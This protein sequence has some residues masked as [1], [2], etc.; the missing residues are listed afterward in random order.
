[1]VINLRKILLIGGGIFAA[2]V[3]IGAAAGSNTT[4]VTP[5]EETSNTKTAKVN[6]TISSGNWEYTV[7]KV[8]RGDKEVAWSDFGNKTTAKGEFVLVYLTLKNI[9]KENFTINSFDFELRDANDV[10]Y[11]DDST[12]SFSVSDY[13]NLGKLGE[14]MPPGV[15]VDT[16][17]VYDVA[18]SAT[19]LRLVLKQANESFITLQQ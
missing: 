15:A 19:D 16:I 5:S 10:K 8:E 1:M 9:G 18:P 12:T 3:V 4:S 13:R 14:Q 7:T 11:N 2:L 17:L 6:E